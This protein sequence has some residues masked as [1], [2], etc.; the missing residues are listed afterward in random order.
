MSRNS[1]L[2][3]IAKKK[4]KKKGPGPGD[5]PSKNVTIDTSPYKATDNIPVKDLQEPVKPMNKSRTDAPVHQPTQKR[6]HR[7]A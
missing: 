7:G 4:K 1:R 2:K 3:H 5:R 6:G